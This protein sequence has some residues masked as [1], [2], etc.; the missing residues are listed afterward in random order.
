MDQKGIAIIVYP[1]QRL[2]SIKKPGY[3][4]ETAGLYSY[5]STQVKT[6]FLR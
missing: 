4:F 1:N 3:F 6:D 5:L 2:Q